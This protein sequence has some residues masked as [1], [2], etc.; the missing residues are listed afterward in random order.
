MP[1]GNIRSSSHHSY[2]RE[3]V[4]IVKY[5]LVILVRLQHSSVILLTMPCSCTHNELR[6]ATVVMA[7]SHIQVNPGRR[8]NHQVVHLGIAWWDLIG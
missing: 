8:I 7:N 6:P 4:I 1:M 2:P 5:R 3:T